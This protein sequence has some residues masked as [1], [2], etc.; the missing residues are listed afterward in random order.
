[1][2]NEVGNAADKVQ[3]V[4]EFRVLAKAQM[5]YLGQTMWVA[6]EQD[7]VCGFE[8]RMP[9]EVGNAACASTL[10]ELVIPEI[11]D[12]T[13]VEDTMDMTPEFYDY[14][15]RQKN[16]IFGLILASCFFLSAATGACG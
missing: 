4:A 8:V 16:M 10:E 1:M 11:H 14:E 3:I 13:V 7:Q 12:T 15:T 2:P 6:E 5:E 9:N